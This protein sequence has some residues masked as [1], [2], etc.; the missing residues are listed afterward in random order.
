MINEKIQTAFNKQIKEE[1]DSAYIYL[2]MA[3][4]MAH[5]GWDGMASWF[6]KQA[7]EETEHAM[8]FYHHIEERD[9]R[10][11]L[12]Q[13]DKPKKEWGTPLGAFKAAYEHEKYITSKI[14]ELYELAKKENDYP[15]QLLLHWFIDEQVEEEANTSK[16]VDMLEKVGDAKHGIFMLDVQ[17]G[18]RE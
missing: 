3:A 15:A 16:I 7:N 14:N 12:L 8:K 11:E 13:I 6:K 2:S 9:G 1:L 10:V 18:K 5:D 17:L 4:Q